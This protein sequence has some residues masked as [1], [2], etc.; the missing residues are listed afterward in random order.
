M[1]P[2]CSEINNLYTPEQQQEIKD[3]GYRAHATGKDMNTNPYPGT[4][5]RH[6]IWRKGY[7]EAFKDS[8]GL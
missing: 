6:W 2:Q 7:L 8:N 5:H 1:E 4:D 3:E